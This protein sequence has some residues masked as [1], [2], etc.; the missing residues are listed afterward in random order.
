MLRLPWVI[1][2]GSWFQ[3][4]YLDLMHQRR[5]VPLYGDGGNIMSFIDNAAIGAIIL[6]L[7]PTDFKGTLNLFHPNH[8]SQKEWARMLSLLSGLPL[9]AIDENDE[10]SFGNAALEAFTTHI[11]LSSKYDMLQDLIKK[12]HHPLED[13]L[14][15][16]LFPL[17]HK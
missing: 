17:E 1:G 12:H 10:G 13:I 6:E 2:Q 15:K 9:R 4:N 11:A 16:Y 7:A 3:W 8:L 5:Y 14:K